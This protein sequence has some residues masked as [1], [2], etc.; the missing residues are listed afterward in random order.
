MDIEMVADEENQ[1][2]AQG[3]KNEAGWVISLVSGAEEQVSY[4]AAENRSDNAE[5]DCPHEGQ[6][7]V[8]YGF[9]EDAC[10]QPNH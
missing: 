1:D 2:S 4:G 7:D 10:K 6:V 5:H 8:H 3:R 9:R